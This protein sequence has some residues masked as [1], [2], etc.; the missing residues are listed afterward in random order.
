MTM[1]AG[2]T[3]QTSPSPNLVGVVTMVAGRNWANV[4]SG[5]SKALGPPEERLEQAGSC[6]NDMKGD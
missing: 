2:E 1:A 6:Q 5:F 3:G 4:S